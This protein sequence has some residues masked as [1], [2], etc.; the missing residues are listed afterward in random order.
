MK[1][2]CVGTKIINNC[3]LYVLVMMQQCFW[4]AVTANTVGICI[5]LDVVYKRSSTLPD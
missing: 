1:E 2:I 3:K 4:F 5:V